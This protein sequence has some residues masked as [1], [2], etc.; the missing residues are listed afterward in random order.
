MRKLRPKKEVVFSR[1]QGFTASLTPLSK[2]TLPRIF[3]AV[4]TSE[5]PKQV[6]L[7]AK[8]LQDEATHSVYR[9]S[10][11]PHEHC[12]RGIP[13]E[14]STLLFPKPP[15]QVGRKQLML[16]LLSGEKEQAMCSGIKKLYS[17]DGKEEAN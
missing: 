10:S 13:T 9:M 2:A 14:R 12:S 15:A 16:K 5:D 3:I 7:H 11:K 17:E 6:S 4:G 8:A 1:H